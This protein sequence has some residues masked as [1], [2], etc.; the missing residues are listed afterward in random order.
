MCNVKTRTEENVPVF[1]DMGYDGDSPNL[2]QKIMI[3]YYF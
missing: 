3:F 2:N 1:D